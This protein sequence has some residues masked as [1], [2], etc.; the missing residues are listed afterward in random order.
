[1]IS[2]S[3]NALT[4]MPNEDLPYSSVC[5]LTIPSGAV[6]DYGEQPTKTFI[7]TFTTEGPPDT[8]SPEIIASA[9][10]A[11]ETG[12]SIDRNVIIVLSELVIEGNIYWDSANEGRISCET[13]IEIEEFID[14]HTKTATRL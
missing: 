2:L 12:V 13:T 7:T 14:Y 4:I 1:M 10:A 5:K 6:L 11:D 8:T 3:K 9:P